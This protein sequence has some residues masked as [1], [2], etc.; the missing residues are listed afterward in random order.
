MCIEAA[1]YSH[2]WLHCRTRRCNNKTSAR[3][4]RQPSIIR[5]HAADGTI[6]FA[7]SFQLPV[8]MGRE[9]LKACGGMDGLEVIPV[10]VEWN[11]GPL[12]A[13]ATMKQ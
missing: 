3:D 1:T 11:E 8:V 4:Q 5:V 7:I 6:S 2:E 9:L 10:I 13:S 12:Y